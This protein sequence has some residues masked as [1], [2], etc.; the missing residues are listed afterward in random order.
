M[1]GG[2]GMDARQL[3]PRMRS[4]AT[5]I[6][7]QRRHVADGVLTLVVQDAMCG[8]LAL[9]LCQQDDALARR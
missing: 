4:Y 6:A 9:E 3:P 1:V 7:E 5:P 8:L 2:T